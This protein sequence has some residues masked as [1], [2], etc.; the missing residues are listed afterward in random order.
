MEWLAPRDESRIV[1]LDI[2]LQRLEPTIRY[3]EPRVDVARPAECLRTLSP[4]RDPIC[5]RAALVDELARDRHVA[6]GD[7]ASYRRHLAKG[8]RGQLAHCLANGRILAHLPDCS[9]YI[10]LS[11]DASGGFIDGLDKPPVD[12]WLVFEQ[13]GVPGEP[14]SGCLFA[15]VPP[16]FVDGVQAAIEVNV[17]DCL[18][19]A[20]DLP[21]RIGKELA[22]ARDR[23]V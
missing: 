20:E 8:E 17:E 16:Q 6:L 2:I 1:L 4:I 3:C 19:W 5:D 9:T 10:G 22:V 11:K 7:S 14:D 21:Y 12:T 23:A 13:L 15:W 18:L